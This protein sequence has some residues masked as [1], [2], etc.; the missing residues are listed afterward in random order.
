LGL[1]CLIEACARRHLLCKDLAP[2]ED[3]APWKLPRRMPT[4]SRFAKIF[5]MAENF[6]TEW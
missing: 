6:I 3:L 4:I 5:I 1:F 2:C